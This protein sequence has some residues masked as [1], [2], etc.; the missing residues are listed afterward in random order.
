MDELQQ[1][2]AEAEEK[3][4][5]FLEKGEPMKDSTQLYMELQ[6]TISASS[7][8]EIDIDAL[9]QSSSL[10]DF[11]SQFLKGKMN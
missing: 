1:V 8:S 6:S 3:A 9:L 10:D 4:S 2:T 11:I 5:L 7:T